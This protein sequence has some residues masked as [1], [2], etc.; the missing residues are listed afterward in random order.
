MN[1]LPD[2]QFYKGYTRKATKWFW[3]TSKVHGFEAI[4][5]Q[6]RSYFGSYRKILLYDQIFLADDSI[7]MYNPGAFLGQ[8]G[9]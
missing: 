3:I 6:F 7:I 4:L 9:L 1:G 5:T 8:I 2:S